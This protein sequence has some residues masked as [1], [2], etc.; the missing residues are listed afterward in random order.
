M[1]MPS[2]KKAKL[3]E[4]AKIKDQPEVVV[5]KDRVL[6]IVLEPTRELAKQVYSGDGGLLIL[7]HLLFYILF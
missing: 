4:K 2:K 3:A 5:S 1:Q 6:A 7:L